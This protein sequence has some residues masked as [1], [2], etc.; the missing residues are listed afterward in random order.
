[1]YSPIGSSLM[2]QHTS[3]CTVDA[4]RQSGSHPP[5]DDMLKDDN[6]AENC[7][8]RVLRAYSCHA[9]IFFCSSDLVQLYVYYQPECWSSVKHAK[10]TSTRHRP[11]ELAYNHQ[12]HST[13]LRVV[14][15]LEHTI[16]TQGSAPEGKEYIMVNSKTVFWIV[17]IMF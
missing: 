6:A 4:T 14:R 10:V 3:P 12:I 1:M 7:G 8:I 9:D 2:A 15:T 17:C 5:G 13:L 16:H 11:C